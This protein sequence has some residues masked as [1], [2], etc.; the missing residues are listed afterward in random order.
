MVISD[1]LLVQPFI[2]TIVN[3]YHAFVYRL[4]FVASHESCQIILSDLASIMYALYS[5]I[6]LLGNVGAL[7]SFEVAL[8]PK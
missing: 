5:L 8:C 3:I 7:P 2:C 6:L 1:C 4:F